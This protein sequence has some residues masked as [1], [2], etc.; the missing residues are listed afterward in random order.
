[1]DRKL[2]VL[3]YSRFSDAS[4]QLLDQIRALPFD[5][6]RVTG[7]TLISVDNPSA[8]KKFLDEKVTVVPTLLVQYFDNTKQKL[9]G[10]YITMWINAV[11][12]EINNPTK[13][14]PPVETKPDGQPGTEDVTELPPLG[15]APSGPEV[16]PEITIQPAKTS[17]KD[18]HDMA[19]AMQKSRDVEEKKL[20]QR[21]QL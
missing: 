5:L 13:N 2:C 16:P 21:P 9:E 12:A 20:S 14:N 18:L 10:E 7:M 11:E 8:R 19:M 15:Q 17:G 1:M 4:K 3:V 6:P